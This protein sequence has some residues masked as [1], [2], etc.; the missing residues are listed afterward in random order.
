M[1][2]AYHQLVQHDNLLP[3]QQKQS[4]VVGIMPS[5]IMEG[6]PGRREKGVSAITE[7]LKVRKPKNVSLRR[8]DLVFTNEGAHFLI[9]D[10]SSLTQRTE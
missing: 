6:L 2:N 7:P 10:G 8:T 9:H 5:T 1:S 4:A 3:V